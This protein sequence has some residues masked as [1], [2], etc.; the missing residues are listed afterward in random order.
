MGE[1]VAE[2]FGEL[3]RLGD[4]V[5]ELPPTW[6]GDLVR[7]LEAPGEVLG[8]RRFALRPTGR[9]RQLH[10]QEPVV[11]WLGK[12]PRPLDELAGL[13]LKPD[14]VDDDRGRVA[15]SSSIEVA[16]DD[17]EPI[18]LRL[19][20]LVDRAGVGAKGAMAVHRADEPP[21]GRHIAGRQVKGDRDTRH[22][23]GRDDEVE[24]TVAPDQETE[25]LGPLEP[26]DGAEEADRT[27]H[28]VRRDLR[29]R[30]VDELLAFRQVGDPAD[31][32]L[33]QPEEA[34]LPQVEPVA[35]DDERWQSRLVERWTS[36]EDREHQPPP[37]RSGR[38]WMS[39]TSR[40]KRRRS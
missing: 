14:A 11:G 24:D 12:A 27:S 31:L 13:Q 23:L 21:S 20:V 25:R 9:R 5:V 8:H 38:R 34:S 37:P 35:S 3:A 15:E 39:C 4:R 17:V 33:A 32:R 26:V 10:L 1:A 6:L 7:G 36:F 22:L 30:V 2:A 28:Q 16:D 18:E 29:Q 40:S 19:V